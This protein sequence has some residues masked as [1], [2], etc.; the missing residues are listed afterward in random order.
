MLTTQRENKE[1]VFNILIILDYLTEPLKVEM[2]ED[3]KHK[4]DFIK[5]YESYKE[6][7]AQE[8]FIDLIIDEL[9]ECVRKPVSERSTFE[10]DIIELILYLIRNSLS[11]S[12]F[13]SSSENQVILLKLFELYLK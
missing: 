7:F 6:I 4:E 3:F 5:N 9:K 2:I 13:T 10:K 11:F 1:I 8:E 12:S